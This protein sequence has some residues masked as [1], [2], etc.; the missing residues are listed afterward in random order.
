M[1][2]EVQSAN[3]IIVGSGAAGTFAAFQ[4]RGRGVLVLDV[5]HTPQKGALSGNFYD[6]RKT[7]GSN[8][9]DLFDDLIGEGFESL[10][11]VFHPYLSP[12]LKAPRM[13]FVTR[14]AESFSP[15]SAHNFTAAMSFAA[16]GL[17]NA[18]GGGLYRFTARDLAGFP[19]ALEDLEP[20]YDVIT[21][22]VG[23]SGTDDDLS[24]FFGPAHGLQPPLKIDSN[25]EAILRRYARRRAVLNQDGLFLGRPRLA[26]LTREHDGRPPYR[27]EA[28]EFF[29]PHNPAVYTP[30]Y[31][32][33]ELVHRREIGYEPGLLVERYSETG[34]GVTVTTRECT[35]GAPR[36]FRCRRLILAAG[37]LNTAKIALRSNDDHA[38]RLPLLDN[39]ISYIP[40]LD[41][42]R[43][44]AALDK[45]IYPAAV[46]NG[47]YSG[48]LHP[49]VI[50]M[51][52][53]GV[54]GTL[55]S[56]YLFDFPL[57]A[58]GNIVAA[59][60]LTPAMTVVQLFYPDTPM[61][62][63][64][65]RL[66]DDGRLELRY[67]SK[68][69]GALEAHLI[70]IFRCMGY[71]GAARLCKYLTPGNSF[72]YGGALPMAATP[73]GRYQTD[74]GGLLVGT[75][76]VY[77]ADAANFSALPSKNHTFTMMANAMRIAEGVGRTLA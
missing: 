17:A 65:L 3:V 32:L 35:S 23:I 67:V 55:R 39:N 73:R 11:N 13:R 51:T 5:G 20:Y 24:R 21:A 16:G 70:K 53:Y 71:L 61:P 63:N 22:K 33:N 26:V 29:Q 64:Y 19:I 31:T 45:E 62:T 49:N 47:V 15:I 54:A 46:L 52:L 77:V 25:G 41:A 8:G 68:R 57:S 60:Y 12:K 6:L 34:T 4:L 76:G 27:Y 28:L 56:D 48:D 7:V 18:W 10:H 1:S 74:R 9:A 44:G 69:S 75:R 42:L 58:R 66:S 50:Q 2:A 36:V 38:T 14:D 40:L 37:A 30:A 59:K 43:I 72:H